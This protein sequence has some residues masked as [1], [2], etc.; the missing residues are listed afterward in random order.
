MATPTV[1]CENF[2]H[3]LKK[4]GIP[5]SNGQILESYISSKGSV[6]S[7]LRNVICLLLFAQVVKPATFISPKLCF[8]TLGVGWMPWFGCLSEIPLL[9][10]AMGMVSKCLW[11][12]S[13]HSCRAAFAEAIQRVIVWGTWQTLVCL[14]EDVKWGWFKWTLE[15]ELDICVR[16]RHKVLNWPV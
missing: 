14:G 1:L 15:V 9:A 10:E 3:K 5:G 2:T 8:V 16:Q 6:V 7:G 4:V 12:A 13:Q 11:N